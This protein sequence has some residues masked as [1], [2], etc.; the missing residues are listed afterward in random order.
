MIRRCPPYISDDETNEEALLS[1]LPTMGGDGNTISAA[2]NVLKSSNLELRRL[3]G[4][5]TPGMSYQKDFALVE[6]KKE[7][8][9]TISHPDPWK[10]S[11]L[12][13]VSDD[14]TRLSFESFSEV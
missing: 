11:T 2:L 3:A 14:T 7:Q 4:S 1:P 8:E 13:Y 9:A 12:P 10:I 5:K 6:K